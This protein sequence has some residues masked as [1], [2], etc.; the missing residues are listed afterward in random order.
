MVLQDYVPKSNAQDFNAINVC[1]P[2]V[3][4]VMGLVK[5]GSLRLVLI[6]SNLCVYQKGNFGHK[7]PHMRRAVRQWEESPLQAKKWSLE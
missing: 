3:T 7:D 4:E 5:M 6:Q 2:E 1:G